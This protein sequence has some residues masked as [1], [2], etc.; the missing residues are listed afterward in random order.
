M[1][2]PSERS[3]GVSIYKVYSSSLRPGE[4]RPYLKT[5]DRSFD[6]S[7]RLEVKKQFPN[8]EFMA[9]QD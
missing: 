2:S 8:D 4:S 1:P 5:P 6:P 3:F 9:A 7:P